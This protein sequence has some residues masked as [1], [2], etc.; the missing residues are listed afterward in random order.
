MFSLRK[1]INKLTKNVIF[2]LSFIFKFVILLVV[3]YFINNK[4]GI[5][6]EYND[7]VQKRE[8]IVQEQ[9]K[10][11]TVSVV[12][13]PNAPKRK[14][15]KQVVRENFASADITKDSFKMRDY[16]QRLYQEFM[17]DCSLAQ[18][19]TSPWSTFLNVLNIVI[20]SLVLFISVAVSV[21]M[22]LGFKPDV[23]VTDSMEPTIPVNSLVVV[24]PVEWEDITVGDHISYY[25]KKE[26]KV[27]NFIHRVSAKGSDYLIMVGDNPTAAGIRDIISQDCIQGREVFVVPFIGGIFVWVKNNAILAFMIL[28]TL[29]IGLL[30]VRKII[31]VNHVNVAFAEY[32]KRR[33]DFEQRME[34]Q[35]NLDRTNSQ[36]DALDAILKR[37]Y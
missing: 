22:M 33:V 37:K 13:D 28:F 26:G 32:V 29:V 27:T 14:V 16:K 5:M 21:G 36:K 19:G 7:D 9:E 6:A 11:D 25:L 4:G 15:R 1:I 3:I 10:L 12:E 17:N 35:E 23:V 24:Q 34:S 2:C 8:F 31:D 30:L 18:I 20:V